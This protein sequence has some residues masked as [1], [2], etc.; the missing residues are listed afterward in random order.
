M[1]SIRWIAVAFALLLSLASALPAGAWEVKLGWD[2]VTEPEVVGYRIEWKTAT[3]PSASLPVV[4]STEIV[5]SGLP[6][7]R[8]YFSVYTVDAFGQESPPAQINY[9]PP[10]TVGGMKVLEIHLVR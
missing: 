1:S 4:T 5:I 9:L 8:V 3:G 7:A 6:D 10:R 2:P